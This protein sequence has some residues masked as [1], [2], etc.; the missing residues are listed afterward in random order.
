[1]AYLRSTRRRS[2]GTVKRTP[3]SSNIV[4]GDFMFTRGSVFQTRLH[5][6]WA[7]E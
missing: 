1:M 3:V 6:A 2:M 7:L 4:Y 5:T